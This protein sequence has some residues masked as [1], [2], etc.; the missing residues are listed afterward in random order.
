MK[1]C[2]IHIV[3]LLDGPLEIH[4]FSIQFMLKKAFSLWD[5]TIEVCGFE[6]RP[7]IPSLAPSLFLYN[8]QD[9]GTCVGAWGPHGTRKEQRTISGELCRREA[10]AWSFGLDV[11]RPWGPHVDSIH[12]YSITTVLHLW[13]AL[14]SL[15]HPKIC[16][17]A[18]D[19]LPV[20]YEANKTK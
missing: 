15:I 2:Q 16:S 1:A 11:R 5:L 10:G 12:C 9:T 4:F 6:W 13:F 3:E 14:F 18:L 17:W 8:L 7:R 19:Y 20:P